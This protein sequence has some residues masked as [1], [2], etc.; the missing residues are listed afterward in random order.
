[1]TKAVSKNPQVCALCLEERELKNSHIIS[2]FVYKALG[3]YDEKHRFCGFSTD[4]AE[5][6]NTHQKGFREHLLCGVCEGRLNVW[7]T[8][9]R[10]VLFGGCELEMS[11]VPDDP[12]VAATARGVDYA[13]F[14]LF[15]MSLLCRAGVSSLEMF[16]LVDLGPHAEQLRL[17]ILDEQPGAHWQYGCGVLVAPDPDSDV[18]SPFSKVID[19]P[20]PF[21]VKSHR[22][23]R[24]MMG[25]MFWLFPVSSQM[26]DME[27]EGFYFSL[28]EDGRLTFYNGGQPTIAYLQK[29]AAD[30]RRADRAREAR[31]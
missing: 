4:P 21:R 12:K 27:Q 3:V 20:E 14:K 11:A 31:T 19:N 5:S 6:V 13:K 9:A 17:L 26:Q 10:K 2:E 29:L 15:S 1:M 22:T 8:Y 30:S 23:Y 18:E 16:E 7:E 24:F 28:F 25:N